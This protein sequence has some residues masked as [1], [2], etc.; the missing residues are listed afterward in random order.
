MGGLSAPLGP[1]T[2]FRIDEQTDG[3]PRREAVR[4]ASR[5][6][7]CDSRAGE[8][9]IVAAEL[10]TNVARHGRGGTIA[11]RR[12]HGTVD[13]GLSLLAVDAGPGIADVST[14][15]RDGESTSSTLGIGLG[16]VARL[17]DAVD[18]YS[19]PGQGTVL[20]ALMYPA[21]SSVAGVDADGLS[22]AMTNEEVCG[23]SFAVVADGRTRTVLLADGLGH[24]PLAA[25]ASQAAVQVLTEGM[26]TGPAKLLADMSHRLRHTRGAAVAVAEIDPA[27]CL[28]RFAGVGNVAGWLLSDDRRQGMPSQPGIVGGAPLKVRERV[29][30]AAAGALVVLH[31][32]GLT[33]KW[34]LS[35]YPGLQGRTAP[36]VA[37]VLM[38][39]AGIRHDDASVAVVKI[40]G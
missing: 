26:T 1:V 14:A 4:L 6:G 24:G 32:D 8:V 35:S 18:I 3:R 40:P 28:V 12:V 31:S 15:M 10:T 21:G 29:F 9:G 17:A 27:E 22:R 11:L 25:A 39:D 7:F 38:R 2:W 16:A 33:D 23:D 36:V 34:A 19:R 5:L 30:A 13:A 20:H 37:A